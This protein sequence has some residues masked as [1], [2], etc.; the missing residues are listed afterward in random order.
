MNLDFEIKTKRRATLSRSWPWDNFGSP[1]TALTS[2]YSP[3]HGPDRAATLYFVIK[4]ISVYFED[5]LM[6]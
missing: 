6:L 5:T 2:F 1:D 3:W 4:I